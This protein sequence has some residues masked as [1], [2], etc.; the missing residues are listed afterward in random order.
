VQHAS[1]P[2]TILCRRPSTPRVRPHDGAVGFRARLEC[3]RSLLP[4][5]HSPGGWRPPRMLEGPPGHRAAL[6]GHRRNAPPGRR[7][8]RPRAACLDLGRLRSRHFT[9]R[10]LA[11]GSAPLPPLASPRSRRGPSLCSSIAG[12]VRPPA[13]PS[14]PPR[15]IA[16]PSRVPAAASRTEAS[17]R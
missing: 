5:S 10:D 11:A 17:P 15:S 8:E 9:C 14:Q 12:D 16:S 6:L 1:M 2:C 7:P 4:S 3:A 13:A